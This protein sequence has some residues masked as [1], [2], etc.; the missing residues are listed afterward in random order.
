[1]PHTD[2]AYSAA[3]LGAFACAGVL[4]GRQRAIVL[5]GLALLVVAEAGLAVALVPAH[6]LSRLG[7]SPAH[8]GGVAVAVIVVLALAA[9]LVRYPG[10]AAVLLLVAAPFRIS[11]A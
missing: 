2:L 11:L 10:V 3:A 6:D 5:S 1:M 4:L 7:A 9:V 8:I